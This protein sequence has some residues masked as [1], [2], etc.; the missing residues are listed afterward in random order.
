MLAERQHRGPWPVWWQ[1]KVFFVRK[2]KTTALGRGKG[3]SSVRTAL[4]RSCGYVGLGDHSRNQHILRV[5]KCVR[6]LGGG[7]LK[8]GTVGDSLEG[9]SFGTF[10][11]T[12]TE[13]YIINPPT[14]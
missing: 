11:S 8:G 6:A 9:R 1:P 14:N 12:W 10:L 4:R 7:F 5:A 2:D 3:A 13:K